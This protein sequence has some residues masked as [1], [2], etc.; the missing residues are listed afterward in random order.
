M[1]MGTLDDADLKGDAWLPQFAHGVVEAE[2]MPEPCARQIASS[3][4][5]TAHVRAIEIRTGE[6]G[7][8]E[9][10]RDEKGLKQ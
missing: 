5:R 4:V 9:G 2:R 8:T 10:R 3:E 6:I 1:P 7:I